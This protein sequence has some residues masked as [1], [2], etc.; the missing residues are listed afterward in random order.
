MPLPLTN[1]YINRGTGP[2]FDPTGQ[3]ITL[4]AGPVLGPMPTVTFG[5]APSAFS[6]LPIGDGSNIPEFP[7]YPPDLASYLFMAMWIAAPNLD[8]G[9]PTKGINVSTSGFSLGGLLWDGTAHEPATGSVIPTPLGPG[10]VLVGSETLI[11]SVTTPVLIL[12]SVDAVN[13][14]IECSINGVTASVTLNPSWTVAPGSLMN[15][16]PAGFQLGVG[17]GSQLGDYWGTDTVAYESAIDPAVISKFIDGGGNPV[18]LGDH[19]EIPFGY[20]P[21]LYFSLQEGTPASGS[22]MQSSIIGKRSA[23]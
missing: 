10:G 18:F 16:A 5:T 7:Q 12:M 4:T 21:V 15:L 20:E 9:N 11:P 23:A 13:Q 14:V 8:A 17:D 3:G 1:W 2:D 19:G 22:M 6:F